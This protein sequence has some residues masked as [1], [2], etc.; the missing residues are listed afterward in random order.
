M[1]DMVCEVIL[2]RDA[3]PKARQLRDN[4][5]KAL[6]AYYQV[7]R[8]GPKVRMHSRTDLPDADYPLNRTA[9]FANNAVLV[10][11]RTIP[12]GEAKLKWPHSSVV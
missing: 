3:I 7:T 8:D 9:V 1:I 6:F 12:S 4:L 10:G 11:R 5:H 2:M